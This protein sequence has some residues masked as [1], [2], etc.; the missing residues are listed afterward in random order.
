MEKKYR[1]PHIHNISLLQLLQKPDFAKALAYLVSFK[2]YKNLEIIPKPHPIEITNNEI[3]ISVIIYSGFELN[4]YKDLQNRTNVHLVS[5]CS[6]LLEMF[7]FKDMLVK[8]IDKLAWMF[9]VINK[10]ENEMVQKINR[11]KGLRGY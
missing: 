3:S 8:H 10:S 11:I 1:Y 6:T 2:N 5:L 4:E 9:C 7:E